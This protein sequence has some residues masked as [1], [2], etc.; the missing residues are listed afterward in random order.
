MNEGGKVPYA[1]GR[2]FT[3]RAGAVTLY[4]PAVKLVWAGVQDVDGDGRLDLI[5]DYWAFPWPRM[6]WLMALS[7]SW[8]AQP[9]PLHV[10]IVLQGSLAVFLPVEVDDAGIPPEFS[11][12]GWNGACARLWG[13]TPEAVVQEIN[14]HC[15]AVDCTRKTLSPTKS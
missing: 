9:R 7:R 11:P 5:G 1:V 2:V 15:A 8:T 10:G 14:R 3:W 13:A 6:R 4:A 12:T